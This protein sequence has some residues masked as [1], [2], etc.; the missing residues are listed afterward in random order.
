MEFR[1]NSREM[2]VLYVDKDTMIC[3]TSI[4]QACNIGVPVESSSIRINQS[5]SW[6]FYFTHLK[7]LH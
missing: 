4:G 7:A 6:V 1:A 3:P 5:G 2:F